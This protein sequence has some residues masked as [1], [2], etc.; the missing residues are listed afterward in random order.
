MSTSNE[1][2][3]LVDLSSANSLIADSET[4]PWC[5]FI[6]IPADKNWVV[7]FHK[8][9]VGRNHF[10]SFCKPDSNNSVLVQD[11]FSCFYDNRTLRMTCKQEMTK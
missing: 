5:L 11:K 1:I 9:C 6:C 7:I 8:G 2:Y 10:F 3:L 4:Y